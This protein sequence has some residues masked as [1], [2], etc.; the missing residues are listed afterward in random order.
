MK[1][2]HLIG[3]PANPF[4]RFLRLAFASSLWEVSAISANGQL[5]EVIY[6]PF[7]QRQIGQLRALDMEAT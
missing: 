6:R 4:Q 3:Q 1:P 2:I 7:F 5:D